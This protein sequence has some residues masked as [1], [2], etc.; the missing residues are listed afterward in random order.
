MRRDIENT[1][2]IIAKDL[3]KCCQNA[4]SCKDCPFHARGI[5]GCRIQWPCRWDLEER[6][7]K[8]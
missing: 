7:E 3:K 2:K 8:R 1:L 4:K 6:D 5:Y